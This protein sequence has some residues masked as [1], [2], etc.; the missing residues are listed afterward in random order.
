M[1]PLFASL[2]LFL[3][4]CG[5]AYTLLA[6]RGGSKPSDSRLR[7]LRASPGPASP[8][9]SAT[10]RRS[11]TSIPGLR[12]LLNNSDWAGETQLRLRQA[13][14][15][16][17]V[18]E[19]LIL[20]VG[21]AAV[22]FGAAV[23]ISRFNIV[24][25]ILGIA[26]AVVGYALPGI[27]VSIARQRRIDTME[28]QLTELAPML[29]SSLRSGFALQQGLELAAH[30]LEPPIADELTQ[31][32]TDLNLGATLDAAMLDFGRR[33]GSPDFDM[34]ITAILIQRTSGGN[35]S[36]VLDRTAETLRERERIRGEIKTLTASQRLTGTILSVYPA[37]LGLL[38]LAIMPS[39][40]GL[41]FT[42]NLGRALVGVA[43]GLQVI[44][45]F[46]MRRLMNVPI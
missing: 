23:L 5:A 9:A 31:L 35:L 8:E 17:R 10:L 32:T 25:F 36:E 33:I 45:F 46:A 29:A 28:R 41:M 34:L 42:E 38:L 24:G 37:A 4:I 44:G 27:F 2:L 11:H 15:H 13:N 26:L 22:L 20:R 18:G 30:Q 3:S 19:Y 12:G 1:L 7:A 43:L 14:I 16:L 21:L 39:M 6:R 40:W